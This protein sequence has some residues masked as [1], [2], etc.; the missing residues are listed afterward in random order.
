MFGAFMF[1]TP[2]LVFRCHPH[3]THYR[4]NKRE[5]QIKPNYSQNDVTKSVTKVFIKKCVKAKVEK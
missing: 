2:I 3:F 5:C 1:D 4:T